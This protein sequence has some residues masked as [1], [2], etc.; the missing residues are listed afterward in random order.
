MAKKEK[1]EYP[2][3]SEKEEIVLML[4]MAAIDNVIEDRELADDL[5]GTMELI[6]EDWEKLKSVPEGK[7]GEGH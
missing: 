2:H 1:R 6:L 4:A 5:V 3:L 7:P